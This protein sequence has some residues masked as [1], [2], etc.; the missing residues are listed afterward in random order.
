MYSPK[1]GD[2]FESRDANEPQ[3]C[4][5][6]KNCVTRDHI[7]SY[8]HQIRGFYITA[9]SITQVAHYLVRPTRQSLI[10]ALQT[11]VVSATV[12]QLTAAASGSLSMSVSQG[13]ALLSLNAAP[14]IDVG[15]MGRIK[16]ARTKHRVDRHADQCA[17]QPPKMRALASKKLCEHIKRSA[18]KLCKARDHSNFDFAVQLAARDKIIYTYLKPLSPP[19]GS[20]LYS[21]STSESSSIIY[22]IPALRRF[23]VSLMWTKTYQ[24][25]SGLIRP[26][27]EIPS[28]L[29]PSETSNEALQSGLTG[30]VVTLAGSSTNH[31]I[32]SAASF[33]GGSRLQYTSPYLESVRA[34]F[35]APTKA[36]AAKSIDYVP[37]E[38]AETAARNR[39]TSRSALRSISPKKKPI[40]LR[41]P[42]TTVPSPVLKD[43]LRSSSRG[44]V[45]NTLTSRERSR[46]ITAP[47][48][49]TPTTGVSFITAPWELD[50]H[51]SSS[52]SVNL[53]LTPTMEDLLGSTPFPMSRPFS[54]RVNP[55]PQE[56][57]QPQA[58]MR[59]IMQGM[60][61]GV[62]RSPMADLRREYKSE[63]E[64]ESSLYQRMTL[65]AGKKDLDK[66]DIVHRLGSP[67]SESSS[68][69]QFSL[70]KGLGAYLVRTI[71][72]MQSLLKHASELVEGRST[73]FVVDPHGTIM[74]VLS[75]AASLS[76][77]TIAWTGLRLRIELSQRAYEKYER[78]FMATTSAELLLLPV[79]TAPEIYDVFPREHS[80]MSNLMYL[81]DHL[82]GGYNNTDWLPN[83][84][85]PPKHLE[86]AFPQKSPEGQ[87]STVFY[88]STGERREIEMS[89][90]TSRRAGPELQA[91]PPETAAERPQ[92][93]SG[94]K[95][96]SKPFKSDK[97]WA[98][99]DQHTGLLGTETPFK[100][101]SEFFKVPRSPSH[102]T[103]AASVPGTNLPNP[104]YVSGES[105]SQRAPGKSRDKAYNEAFDPAALKT[106][107][108]EEVPEVDE[109][110]FHQ[111]EGD[112][113]PPR[114]DPPQHHDGPTTGGSVRSSRPGSQRSRRSDRRRQGAGAGGAGDPS[115]GSDD[116]AGF[117]REP[118]PP[119]RRRTHPPRR[120]CRP[121][122][123]RRSPSPPK[124]GG[125]AG[126]GNGGGDGG[127]GGGG[128]G[129][130]GGDGNGVGGNYGYPY[131]APGAPYGNMVPM[132]E[133]KIKIESLPEWDGDHKTA[134]NYFWQ[135][136]QVRQLMAQG[137][138]L[139]AKVRQLMA[140]VRQVKAKR[141]K[142]RRK[143]S[144][145]RK[146][147]W[148][149]LIFPGYIG[150]AAARHSGGYQWRKAIRLPLPICCQSSHSQPILAFHQRWQHLSSMSP[151]L[152]TLHRFY[153]LIFLARHSE[154]SILISQQ[155][156][157]GMPRRF[158]CCRSDRARSGT[159]LY[160][161]SGMI[162]FPGARVGTI[163]S[164]SY[165]LV[166]YS[167]QPTPPRAPSTDSSS[168]R[169]F[170]HDDYGINFLM[171][172]M[173][174]EYSSSRFSS[175]PPSSIPEDDGW[176][177]RG[178]SSNDSRPVSAAPSSVYGDLERYPEEF[179]QRYK[180]D[181]Q[182]YLHYIVQ[183][184][185][186]PGITYEHC[187]KMTKHPSHNAV[188]INS[189][190]ADYGATLFCDALSRFIVQFNNPTFSRAEIEDQS[191]SVNLHFNRV[192][193][194]HRI[195]PICA[196]HSPPKY[197]AY[198]Q[199]F[200]V[201]T[202]QPEPHHPMYKVRRPLK[203]GTRIAEH[204]VSYHVK[205]YSQN[206]V[207]PKQIIIR[208]SN[209]MWLCTARADFEFHGEEW[210]G[211]ILDIASLP[212]STESFKLNLKY[213]HGGTHNL[214]YIGEQ[215]VVSSLH[216]KS[217]TEP[218]LFPQGVPDARQWDAQL[219]NLPMQTAK[220]SL[221]KARPV[222]L[223]SDEVCE[224][225][226]THY[227]AY[228]RII[229]ERYLGLK[230]QLLMNV[231]FE[232]QAFRQSGQE[233]ESP[234]AFLG[235]RVQWVRMLANSDDGSPLEVF[236]V[237][238][239]AP[240]QWRTIL[241]LENIDSIEELY[242]RVNEHDDALVEAARKDS[243]DTL[244]TH[245]V[246]ATLK[247]MGFHPY[248][249]PSQ[250]RS[251]R[252]ANRA[253]IDEA[254]DGEMETELVTEGAL[255]YDGG[256][257]DGE[258]TLRQVYQTMKS[259]PCAPPKGR[260]PYPKNDHVTTK[261][262][263]APSSPCKRVLRASRGSH[264][265][266]VFLN[267]AARSL[268]NEIAEK[269]EN[270]H[271][272]ETVNTQEARHVHVEEVEDKYWVNEARM[273]KARAA[274]VLEGWDESGDEEEETR[275][276]EV[277]TRIGAEEATELHREIPSPLPT[278]ME[279]IALRPKRNP[280]PG[281]SAI[282]VSVLAVRGWIGSLEDTSVMLR[283]DF[284]KGLHQVESLHTRC[285]RELIETEAEAYVV[286]GMGVPILLGED[287]Q[288]NYELGVSRNVETGTKVLFGNSPYE[289]LATGVDPFAGR[290]EVHDLAS[291][292]TTDA[293]RFTKAKEHRRAKAKR[294]RRWRKNGGIART[295]RAAEDYRVRAHESRN[296]RVTGDFS[297]D[298][299]WL[300]EKSL[301]ANAEGSFFTVPNTLISAR[302]PVVPISDMSERPRFIRKG[303]I[304]GSLVDP[305]IFF[306]K[307]ESERGLEA[308]QRK[309]ALVSALI[310]A[311]AEAES[312]RERQKGKEPP[313]RAAE[314][315]PGRRVRTDFGS[316][317]PP[318][319]DN[320]RK[321]VHTRDKNG[322]VPDTEGK[323]PN[324]EE[325]EDYGP[326]TAAMPDDTVYPSA[327]METLLDVWLKMSQFKIAMQ[328]SGCA[329]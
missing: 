112:K 279:S 23:P 291:A 176:S 183:I 91:P 118:D 195:K 270:E 110:S 211:L 319:E 116:D 243:H 250:T 140:K 26:I 283:L 80:A 129:N 296:V 313:Q 71:S 284:H 254:A 96:S 6:A 184:R 236:L 170:F 306:D 264:E 38:L 208:S 305:Q 108:L 324:A 15:Y 7:P 218:R 265:R 68:S 325:A 251:Y 31:P 97:H 222:I 174:D 106:P 63:T 105:M 17:S 187:L 293:R 8:E 35:L 282:G 317:V 117:H 51:G 321:G 215:W 219:T 173:S 141:R 299:E 37:E 281:N 87:P 52:F 151:I 75:G 49:P 10:I 79:S 127:N 226:R 194:Y 101:P 36:S 164:L 160:N 92:R 55:S 286:E 138:Q 4:E 58:T 169:D 256:S 29:N 167:L 229:K 150:T 276:K 326:K 42:T 311:R 232:K 157:P 57:S 212:H 9:P 48:P 22:E 310:Q 139:M 45:L 18:G 135:D 128:G 179:K 30:K 255:Q 148:M 124:H 147:R 189:L 62:A 206:F 14:T 202:A 304:L 318:D 65:L 115:N 137:R 98:I 277:N 44:R 161:R 230:W 287:Y 99:G 69:F 81:F 123:G 260:Y 107:H 76:E 301:L 66:T 280:K 143:R 329:M 322:R 253:E 327:D 104:L 300:V 21:S 131:S 203:D 246:V 233:Q 154:P 302:N 163:I 93:S 126:G 12:S 220:F 312:Q 33:R 1:R 199:W 275:G 3:T 2:Q 60:E 84:V 288:L 303:E 61:K 200:S 113:L 168:A 207:G 19:A 308:I 297:E 121:P 245:N 285:Y 193:V 156:T 145:S 258:S 316:G 39:G 34:R 210:S 166:V 59:P 41:V 238:R 177:S 5:S 149:R 228:L 227:L 290:A 234:Q 155:P 136:R 88:S 100:K 43:R 237:M 53:P 261:M 278:E 28:D 204:G 27:L 309:T 240:I 259:R 180:K 239:K 186:A 77:M 46:V 198:V 119:G 67:E 11:G 114:R 235:R 64:E 248:P 16:L 56:E 274:Y 213:L 78:E 142:A 263:K 191:A 32:P 231:E 247:R 178:W 197:L 146:Q 190:V 196:G 74:Q 70:Q 292:L 54:P 241:V 217:P 242:K 86:E 262:G 24:V 201:F 25:L 172:E 40:S 50:L 20:H 182:R 252:R 158:L 224:D 295:I 132:I 249:S 130:G 294:R 298:K 152:G 162:L 109:D 159:T 83:Y 266:R 181:H 188:R 273:P 192:A 315:E 307:P 314:A 72:E 225:S 134:I 111:R 214:N 328:N 216:L 271:K 165:V 95:A 205:D 82:P 89:E 120:A 90:R 185:L 85:S 223:R 13:S 268:V 323:L 73:C 175:A 102:S 267:S 209:A 272:P 221:K 289:V 320:A 144:C 153:L 171:G 244:T 269:L 122:E 47:A 103:A 125:G 257:E 133:P 94:Q